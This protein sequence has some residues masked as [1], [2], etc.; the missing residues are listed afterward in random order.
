M[1]E[2]LAITLSKDSP[3]VAPVIQKE[4]GPKH[5][6]LVSQSFR[7]NGVCSAHFFIASARLDENCPLAMQFSTL[8]LARLE[9]E[10]NTKNFKCF[11]SLTSSVSS[12]Y[13][14]L[15]FFW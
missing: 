4:I 9:I 14:I 5:R 8:E 10:K 15:L 3:V 6:T 11:C 13:F 1:R 12:N 7:V 2:H